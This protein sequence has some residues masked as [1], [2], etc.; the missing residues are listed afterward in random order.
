MKTLTKDFFK[1]KKIKNN[2]IIFIILFGISILIFIPW[3]KIHYSIDDYTIATR[4]YDAYARYW[5]LK[6]GRLFQFV[7]LEIASLIKMPVNIFIRLNVLLSIIISIFSVM[8]IYNKMLKIKQEQ[9][10]DISE[11]SNDKISTKSK[12]SLLI[13]SYIT[14]FNFM[15]IDCMYY[16]EST[17]MSISILLNILAAMKI[18]D[19][20]KK[21][22]ITSS[23]LVLISS[24]CYQ[25]TICVY[26]TFTYFMLLLKRK[27]TKDAAIKIIQCLVISFF[28][29]IANY[30][31]MKIQITKLGIIQDRIGSFKN[32]KDNLH[33]I[34]ENTYKI[35]TDSCTLYPKYI[36]IVFLEIAY[37]ISIFKLETKDLLRTVMLFIIS[38]LSS[39]IFFI[40]TKTSFDCGRMRISIGMI[41]G[42]MYLII[43][44][45]EKEK[46]KANRIL[47]TI[48]IFAILIYILTTIIN[49]EIIMIE[50]SKVNNLEKN[51][52]NE[53]YQYVKEYEE[54]T[55]IE[56]K[57]YVEVVDIEN[58][59]KSAYSNLKVNV[60]SMNI[61][62]I[63]H[64]NLSYS[65]FYF[66]TGLKLSC[67][68]S[69][70]NYQ[71]N[72]NN[73]NGYECFN[74]TL[75]VKIYRA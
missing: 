7:W 30:I 67:K 62:G 52:A 21:D 13:V 60:N 49:F 25:G 43:L 29:M 8:L 28:S 42:M 44:L 12:I 59:K 20:N 58:Y 74:D 68:D 48:E 38:I 69:I 17:V 75:Y 65:T 2:M 35:L 45:R 5:S 16:V 51:E 61:S 39:S 36:F 40:L 66:Y 63:R 33:Y 34:Q 3:L 72:M 19:G 50:Q 41:L 37:A 18:I 71:I 56:V 11:N 73:D 32:I 10:T 9:I 31:F 24:F 57:N 27:S 6:D 22:I 47:E 23:I 53:I 46:N 54:K 26:I 1:N 4:G 55:G 64:Y 70:D 14:I 15:Y